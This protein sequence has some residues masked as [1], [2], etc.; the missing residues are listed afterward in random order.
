MCCPRAWARRT[1]AGFLLESARALPSP[2]LVCCAMFSTRGSRSMRERFAH[3]LDAGRVRATRL[4]CPAVVAPLFALML[5]V[6]GGFCSGGGG[7]RHYLVGGDV[8][9]L[10]VI[11]KRVPDCTPV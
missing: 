9:A 3:V 7:G 6:L 8:R 2:A 1:Y 4:L 5:A 10:R 11:Y